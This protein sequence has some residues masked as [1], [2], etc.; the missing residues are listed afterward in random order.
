MKIR[1]LSFGRER[2][3]RPLK[4]DTR[5]W[6]NNTSSSSKEVLHLI[7][8]SHF[9][10][11][12]A[13]NRILHVYS[14]VMFQLSHT[15]ISFLVV[16]EIFEVYSAEYHFWRVLLLQW[17]M[18]QIKS[19]PRQNISRCGHISSQILFNVGTGDKTLKVIEYLET[20]FDVIASEIPNEYI[21]TM[22][23]NVSSEKCRTYCSDISVLLKSELDQFIIYLECIPSVFCSTLA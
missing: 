20:Y 9:L 21:M 22:H 19:K 23:C 7:V 16:S 11:I 13:Y 2:D 3:T 12:T 14:K 4:H 17:S 6:E 5:P 1:Y 10:Y 18:G 8:Y 15:S